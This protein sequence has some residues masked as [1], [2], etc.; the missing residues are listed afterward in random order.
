MK[1]FFTLSFLFIL[2]A[3]LLVILTTKK[4]EKPSGTL[5]PENVAKPT[6]KFTA[7]SCHTTLKFS[8]EEYE[9]NWIVVEDIDKIT[10]RSNLEVKL[11]AK[12]IKENNLCQHLISGGFFTLENKHIGLF[13]SEEKRISEAENSDLF[14]GYFYIDKNNKANISTSIPNFPKLALQSG[15]ILIK[16]DKPQLLNLKNDEHARRIVV[17]LNKNGHTIFLAIYD[18]SNFIKGPL[19]SELPRLLVNL[20][21]NTDL[22]FQNALNLDGGAHSTFISDTIVLTELSTIGGWFC[23]KP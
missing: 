8:D 2:L 18:K 19:L 15:P 23:V 13:I 11:T 14:N 4:V 9:V 10:L 7:P 12:E 17:A 1:K 6:S 21:K 20:E 3:G 16:N 5:L 22:D